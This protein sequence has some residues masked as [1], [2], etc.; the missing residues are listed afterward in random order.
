M[1][2]RSAAAFAYGIAAVATAFLLL[3]HA[4]AA[5]LVAAMRFG[6]GDD[7]ICWLGARAWERGID[8]YSP[9]GLQWA[10]LPSLGQMPTATLWYLPFT[11][12]EIF[13]LNAVYGQFLLLLLLCHL[14]LVATELRAPVPLATALLG[15]ALVCDTSWWANH[16]AMIQI[17]E[18]IAL[19]YVLAWIFLRRDHEIAAGVGIGLAMTLKPFGALLV[20]MLLVGRRWRGA[21]AAAAVFVVFAAAASWRFGLA[22]W[23]EWLAMMPATENQWMAHIRNA[24]LQGIVLRWW[25]PACGPRGPLRHGATALA[26]LLSLA[27]VAA[28]A[29]SARRS[30]ARKSP[31]PAIDDA[32]DLPFALFATASAWL[33]PYV[34]EHYDVLLVLP[35]GIALFAAWRAPTRVWTTAVTALLVAVALLLSVDMWQKTQ[36]QQTLPAAHR[37]MHLY[38]VANWLPWP[39]TL[40][41]LGALAWRRARLRPA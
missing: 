9:A 18:T 5:R 17:S 2:A 12:Y 40:A 37:L 3:R 34:W 16:V 14:V 38:E 28:I 1:R 35:M 32:I 27:I 29:W 41:A 4:F 24:S 22:C 39:L 33:N 36:L 31:T 20:I 30:L 7:V 13:Q 26:L 11:G 19:L 21:V 15:Y 10:Q 23:R 25:W 8:I 6:F